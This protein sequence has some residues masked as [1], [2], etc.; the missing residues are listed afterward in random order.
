[1]PRLVAA[2]AATLLACA[3]QRLLGVR[4]PKTPDLSGWILLSWVGA[5]ARG[6]YDARGRS[7]PALGPGV[8]DGFLGWWPEDDAEACWH[9]TADT[10][11]RPGVLELRWRGRVPADGDYE[12]SSAGYAVRAFG[13]VLARGS[14]VGHFW[15]GADVAVEVA[16]PHCRGA[17][18]TEL[19]TARVA[20]PM[21]REGSFGGWS[22]LPAV[23]LADCRA[24]DEVEVRV[25]LVAR[26]NHGQVA[27]DSFGFSVASDRE[28][29]RMFGL[30][31]ARALAAAERPP[32]P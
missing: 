22:E 12:V 26:A 20:L 19:V 13:T 25:Q 8:T 11:V 27:V 7:C 16:S 24:G 4:P 1:V 17:W 9:D 15:A 29:G 3:P 28:L 5:A 10:K 31:R 23:P 6:F 18:A 21:H 30:R 14:Y 32:N 2:V